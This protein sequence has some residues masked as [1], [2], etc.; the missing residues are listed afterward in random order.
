VTGNPKPRSSLT[1]LLALVVLTWLTMMIAGYYVGHKPFD[2]NTARAVSAAFLDLLSVALLVTLGGALGSLI[3]TPLPE[4]QSPALAGEGETERSDIVQRWLGEGVGGSI[5]TLAIHA[6]LGLGILSLIIFAL[7][8]LALIPSPWLAWLLTLAGLAALNRRALAWL[9]ALWDTLHAF[10][11]EDRW[12]RFVVSGVLALLGMALIVSL[13]PPNKWDAL[14][15]HLTAPAAYLR[16]GRFVSGADNHFFGFPQAVEMLYLW[17]MR[18]RGLEGTA[19]APLHFAFGAWMLLLM[20]G[21][22]QRLTGSP[23]AG[24]VAAAILLVSDSFWGEFAW[25]YVDLASAA[26][27]LAAFIVIAA[28][29]NIRRAWLVGGLLTGFALSTKYTLAGPAIGLGLLVLWSNRKA[30]AASA[31]WTAARFTAVALAVLA[32]W[33][34]KN[35]LLDGNPLFP[36]IFPTAH[37]DAL[38]QT[39]YLRPGTGLPLWRLLIAPLDATIVGREAGAPYGS[40]AGALL[41]A[42]LPAVIVSWRTRSTDQRAFVRAALILVAPAYL[43][44][45]VGNGVSWFLVQTRLLFPVFPLLALVGALGLEGLR[46]VRK[47]LDVGWLAR[48][49]VTLVMVLT[50]IS[51][52][53][54]FVRSDAT[55]VVLGL[56]SRDAYLTDRLGW[57]YPAVQQLDSLPPDA[58]VLFLWE[59]R[60]FHCHIDCT[61]DSLLNRWWHDRQLEPDPLAIARDWRDAG[62]TH[63][64]IHESGLRF[65]VEEEPYEL[66]DAAD[67]AAF[68][69]LRDEML[70]IVWQGGD[71]YTLYAWRD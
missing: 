12:T 13:A 29:A 18:L 70:E 26:Y 4:G 34:I 48:S 52:V 37:F 65:L 27:T 38:D 71:A 17:L 60:T 9:R 30:G 42:L 39:Y 19:A 24:W 1:P 64:L 11:F 2:A 45:L 69:R 5:E 67:L 53:L 51:G 21:L 7:V 46:A 16:A 15:Y 44:W 36:L 31:V 68:D 47:P 20:L 58:K 56:Q 28:N 57:Y 62:Y 66:L 35:A 54:S 50:L 43:L 6:L 63:I 59:P 33:L 55:R 49:L 23:R 32:P 3:F 10:R 61:P 40:S 8:A 14:V 41:V 22:S 25:P